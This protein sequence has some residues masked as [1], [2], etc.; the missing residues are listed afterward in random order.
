MHAKGLAGRLGK[1]MP[2]DFYPESRGMQTT[3]QGWLR[4]FQPFTKSKEIGLGLVVLF[5]GISVLKVALFVVYF[6]V[7]FMCVQ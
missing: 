6:I 2:P 4:R 7:L 5:C 3:E 1:I